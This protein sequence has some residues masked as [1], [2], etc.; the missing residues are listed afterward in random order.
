MRIRSVLAALG[1]ATA[2]G[3]APAANAAIVH[4]HPG[5]SIQDAIDAA[6][7]G[8]TIAVA[9]GVYRENLT[10]T[11][12]RLTLRGAGDRRTVLKPAETPTASFCT[13]DGA[14]NGICVVGHF[15]ANGPTDPIVGTKIKRMVVDGF[16]GFGIALFNAKNSTV[17][18]SVAR[19]NEEYGISGFVLEEVRFLYNAAHHNGEPGFYIGD[20]PDADA[21]VIGNRSHHN[22]GP[23]GFGFLFRDAS[24]GVVRDNQAWDNCAGMVFADTGEN[25]EPLS[26]WRA[27]DNVV[28][29]NNASCTGETGGPP[30]TSGIGFLLLG[31]DHIVVKENLVR[32]NEPTGPSIASGG[33]AMISST[34][35]GG[36][37]PTANRIVR[38][39]VRLNS[40]FDILWE[41]RKSVV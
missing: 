23:E 2:F 32:R 18:H 39:S 27:W 25:P 4:V 7:P 30:P 16:A 35:I 21:V 8:D 37:D 31:G 3:V 20:S 41:D 38:N 1:A 5:Q 11:T 12:D 34:A 10:I 9:P 29:H 6:E 22:V 15:D 26:D 28:S 13:E 40:P 17:A 19:N 14:V 24:E 33:I 36:S